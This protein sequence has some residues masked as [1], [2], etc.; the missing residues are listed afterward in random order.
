MVTNLKDHKWILKSL[1]NP[2][3]SLLC[4]PHPPSTQTI[5]SGKKRCLHNH[6]FP[7]LFFPNI[8]RLFQTFLFQNLHRII[9]KFLIE[10]TSGG[11]WFNLL[12][13]SWVSS[14][15][16]PGLLRSSSS[17]VLEISK[18]KTVQPLWAAYCNSSLSCPE[19]VF[20]YAQLYYLWLELIN[21][22]YRCP[23]N[24]VV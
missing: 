21:S 6:L 15:I 13:Q 5:H 3:S 7:L 9:E 2:Q 16:R 17:Q 12:L 23:Y 4:T 10:G 11:L 24:A 18:N 1:E 22:H 20:P 8:C 19:K 14:Q